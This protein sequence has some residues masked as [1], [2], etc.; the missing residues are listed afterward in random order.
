MGRSARIREDRWTGLKALT[1]LHAVGRGV[2]IGLLIA[3]FSRGEPLLAFAAFI[4]GLG[5]ILLRISMDEISFKKQTL[6]DKGLI[7]SQTFLE[8]EYEF[9][10]GYDS[11]DPKYNEV[12]RAIERYKVPEYDTGYARLSTTLKAEAKEKWLLEYKVKYGILHTYKD[13]P[14]HGC[15]YCKPFKH[16]TP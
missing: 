14:F 7:S 8:D 1:I 12:R 5:M 16:L 4:L 10:K 11:L 6:L 15:S 9:E 2:A 13:C 3:A